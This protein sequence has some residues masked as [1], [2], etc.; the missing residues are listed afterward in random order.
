[1]SLRYPEMSIKVDGKNVDLCVDYEEL[2]CN[3]DIEIFKK[4]LNDLIEINQVVVEE[5]NNS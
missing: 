1:M 2:F 5:Y 3:G 4:L